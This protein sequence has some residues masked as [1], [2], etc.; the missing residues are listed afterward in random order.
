MKRLLH[1]NDLLTALPHNESVMYIGGSEP[2][3]NTEDE[4][5]IARRPCKLSSNKMGLRPYG[6]GFA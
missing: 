1:V 2:V 6:T 4:H 5:T 3:R